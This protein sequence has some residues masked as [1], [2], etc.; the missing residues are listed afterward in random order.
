MYQF[1]REVREAYERLNIS[2]AIYQV[3]DGKVMTVLVS[4]GFCRARKDMREHLA[5]ALDDSMFER[6]YP[7][8]AGKL[9]MLGEEFARHQKPYNNIFRACDEDGNIHWIH[10]IGYWQNMPDG[11]ELAFCYYLN[12]SKSEEQIE[13]YSKR[14]LERQKDFFFIDSLTELPNLNYF[15]KFGDEK[16]NAIRMHGGRPVLLYFDIIDLQ[17]YNNQY[18]YV[19]GNALLK[20]TAGILRESYPDALVIRGADDRFLVLTEKG[21]GEDAIRLVRDRVIQ[22]SR[23]NTAGVKV[24][25]CLLDPSDTAFTAMDHALHAFKTFGTDMN[26]YIAYFTPELDRTYFRQKRLIDTFENDAK[27]EFIQV[28]YQRI[29]LIKLDQELI[30]N[31]GENDGKNKMVIRAIIETSHKLGI[32]ILCEE[33]ETKD[34]YTFVKEAGCDFIQGFYLYKPD[35]LEAIIREYGKQGR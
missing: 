15:H 25:V 30:R 27:K 18:G 26:S 24:S 23:G 34:Q 32:R 9:A 17:S 8:D 1:S 6:I 35:S 28:Y 22:N 29:D 16:I 20:M 19:A 33:I 3:I 7:E 4:D 11:T 13:S 10:A 12:L 5:R 31:L 2:M 14:Y 21:G